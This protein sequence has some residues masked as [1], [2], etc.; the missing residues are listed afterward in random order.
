MEMEIRQQE[1][2]AADRESIERAATDYIEAW[3]TA[4]VERMADCLHPALTKR[5]IDID[6]ASGRH[7]VDAMTHRDMVDATRT[8]RGKK[9][10]R[11]YE[12][13]ILDVFRNVATSKVDSAGYVDYLHIGRFEDRWR[14][15]NVL[16]EPRTRGA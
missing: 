9:L 4:D 2:S 11:D 12:V 15:V 13:T 5:A 3:L 14:I 1:V 7:S 6:P 16:W 10:A 8:A